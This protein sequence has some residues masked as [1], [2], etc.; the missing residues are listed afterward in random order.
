MYL[1]ICA[2]PNCPNERRVEELERELAA[3]KAELHKARNARLP[4]WSKKHRAY[5]DED[6]CPVA[7]EFGQHLG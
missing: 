3:L 1:L 2:D 7:D 6:G 5:V 4:H